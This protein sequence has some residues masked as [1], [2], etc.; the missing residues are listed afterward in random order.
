MTSVD[1]G[2]AHGLHYALQWLH[3]MRMDN[4]DF[5]VDSKM[6]ADAFNSNRT[7]V[8]E[9]GQIIAACKELFSSSFVNS[10]VE[11][12]RRQANEVAHALACEATRSAS[13]N[14]YLKVPDCIA[15][16]VGNEML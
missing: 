10:R 1:V 5:V 16:I 9:F 4:V 3:D 6:V 15:T 12:N 11:F 7:N 14:I 8:T 2:E 13:P